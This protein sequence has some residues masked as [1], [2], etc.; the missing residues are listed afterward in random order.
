ML[1]LTA[2]RNLGPNPHPS[3]LKG[4]TLIPIDPANV[5]Q[6]NVPSANPCR[7]MPRNVT[8]WVDE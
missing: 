3:A 6:E 7:V 8:K 4:K 1:K 2:H 5:R